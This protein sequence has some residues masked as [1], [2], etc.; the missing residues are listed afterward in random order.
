LMTALAA[1]LGISYN[2]LEKKA[3]ENLSGI[4]TTL[5]IIFAIGGLTGTWM[6]SGTVPAIIYHGM[7]IMS[8]KFFL[9][10]SL[11]L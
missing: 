2:H 5:F 6:A 11:L 3:A 9:P 4:L 7:N 10:T 8:A 1:P